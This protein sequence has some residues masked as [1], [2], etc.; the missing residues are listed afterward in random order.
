MTPLSF[1]T[2]IELSLK[3]TIVL[4]A[5]GGDLLGDVAGLGGL[6]SPRV[7]SGR[8]RAAGTSGALGRGSRPDGTGVARPARNDASGR[9]AAPPRHASPTVRLNASQRQRQASSG[10]AAPQRRSAPEPS[11]A[12]VAMSA[13]EIVFGVWAVGAVVL[14]VRLLMSLVGAR[15]IVRTAETVDDE[16]WH[17]ELEGP[18]RSSASH[19]RLC[20]CGRRR[21]R[22]P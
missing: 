11:R 1:D 3:G 8:L 9:A 19:G 4:C 15:R 5:A 13:T 20:C 16:R 18:P 17:E 7:G 21:S 6:A 14:L 22:C 10:M 12:P 2:W